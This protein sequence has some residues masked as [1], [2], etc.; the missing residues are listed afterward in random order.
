MN[1]KIPIEFKDALTESGAN[2]LVSLD[3]KGNEGEVLDSRTHSRHHARKFPIVT[4]AYDWS[5]QDQLKGATM[6]RDRIEYIFEPEKDVMDPRLATWRLDDTA[7]IKAISSLQFGEKVLETGCS[8][9]TVSIKI[10]ELPTVKQVVGVDLRKDAI[11][12]AEQL[13]ESLASQHR[14]RADTPL[15]LTFMHAAIEELT[16]MSGY[17]DSVCAFEILEHMTLSDFHAAVKSMQ[18]FLSD[19]GTFFV[20]VPNRYPHQDF[21][22]A[23]RTRWNAPDHKNYFSRY[24]LSFLLRKHYE[25]VHIIEG[26]D[27]LDPDNGVYLLAECSGKKK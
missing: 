21:E 14:L 3:R 10:A 1:S 26:V 25:R 5:R 13:T 20:S 17:F 8:S 18:K 6:H 19:E 12:K 27:T 23:R 4:D 9:G 16:Y 24:S 7:R 11:E 22:A 2:I 15:K